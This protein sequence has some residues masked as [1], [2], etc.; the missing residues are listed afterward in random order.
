MIQASFHFPRGFL[1]GTATA[2]HQVEGNNT[3]NNWCAWEQAAGHILENHTSG[4]ACDWWGG[5]WRED[6]DR[7]A[8]AGQNAHRLSIEWSR[9]QPTPDRWD[10]EALDRYI[11]MLR[12]LHE[13]KMTPLVTLHHFTD[14]IWLAELGGW[15]NEQVVGYFNAYVGKVVE[16]LREYAN[17]WVTINE[18][19]VLS[20]SAYLL[21]IWPPGIKSLG[22]AF[23]VMTNLVRAHAAA[24]H[25]IHRIQPQAQVGM[26]INYRPLHPLRSWNPLDRAAVRIYSQMFNEFFPTALNSGVLR[27]PFWFRR[28]REA[29][30]TQDYLG[31][32]YYTHDYITANLSNLENVIAKP[33]FPPGSDV[34]PSGMIANLPSG[35]FQGI[36]WAQKFNV[37]VI[38]TENGI[39]DA[40]DRIRPRYLIQHLHQLWRAVNFN[41]PVK[42]YFHWTLV[43]NFEW[44]RGWTQ[45]FG[46]WELDVQTQARRKRPSADLYAEICLENGL[47]TDMVARYAPEI[48]ASMFQE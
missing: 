8:A 28:V 21:G 17:L 35:M 2:S 6:F 30:G 19:N 36:R 46:L 22:A 3:L 5:R 29:K 31:V 4:L 34:S 32:N 44:E 24:Y 7:A 33:P 48:F 12:G 27:F 41:L 26:A 9:I 18:P 20:I 37:P 45:R 42:G 39:E 13:R 25:T 16:A 15:G 1:W 11:E 23:E 38:V 43:D 10:E 40:D 47:S 14:P